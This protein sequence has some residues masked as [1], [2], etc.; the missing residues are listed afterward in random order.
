MT[1]KRSKLLV[2]LV[3][4]LLATI[5]LTFPV[6]SVSATPPD[7]EHKVTICHRTN[8]DTNPY[9]KITV[10]ESAVDGQ[11]GADHFGEH[12]GPIWNSSL[13][14]QKIEWGD[15]IPPVS[16]YHSG[17]NWTA[18]GQALLANGCQTGASETTST[19][20]TTST[21]IVTT[22]TVP[23]VTTTVP[24]VTTTVPTDV[25]LVPPTI[26]ESASELPETG[27]GTERLL[28]LAVALLFIGAGLVLLGSP[29]TRTS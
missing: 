9:V 15:I 3:A 14:A 10:D 13:K 8:S 4:A 23:D 26:I 7:P 20:S 19:T 24:G 25:T 17:Q 6:G 21:T 11:K 18:E 12:K 5:T 16:L 29:L 28:L 22:T 2:L 27:S 1:T